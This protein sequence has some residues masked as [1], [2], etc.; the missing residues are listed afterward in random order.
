MIQLPDM[1]QA[2][3]DDATLRELIAD[4]EQLGSDIEVVQKSSARELVD[5]TPLPP[6]RRGSNSRRG[7]SAPSNSGTTTRAPAGATR[8]PEPRAATG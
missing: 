5:A 8:S 2:T 4:V 6:P 3:L 1:H 7:R